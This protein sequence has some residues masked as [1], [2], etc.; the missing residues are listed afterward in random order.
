MD[1]SGTN[2]YAALHEVL[3]MM[4]YQAQKYPEEWKSIHHVIVLLTDGKANMG[5]RPAEMIRSIRHFLNIT[6]R[7][8]DYLGET[9]QPCRYLL[10]YSSIPTFPFSSQTSMRLVSERRRIR[11]SSANWPPRR[12][13]KNMFLS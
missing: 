3:Q 5:G 11:Q 6:D 10:R 1:K 8:E 9:H 4:S 2:T 7:R 12:R 13:M